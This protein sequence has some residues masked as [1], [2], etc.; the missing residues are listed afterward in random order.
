MKAAGLSWT[1]SRIDNYA[2]ALTDGTVTIKSLTQVATAEAQ[3]R[4]RN[5]EQVAVVGRTLGLPREFID[6]FIDQFIDSGGDTQ[7]AIS[8][9]RDSP[10]YETYFP[11]N[12]REDG[13]V[14][15]NEQQY[16]QVTESYAA[17]LEDY[18]INPDLYESK[19]GEMV[20]GDV[21]P[22]EFFGRVDAINS[23]ILQAPPEVREAFAAEFGVAE[24]ASPAAILGVA[25]APDIGAAVRERRI[26]IAQVTGQAQR[27]GFRRSRERVQEL[28]DL[29]MTGQQAGQFYSGAAA[30]VRRL[31]AGS[32]MTGQDFGI[33]TV[34]D[35]ATGNVNALSTLTRLDAQERSR[36]STAGQV[37]S[38]RTGALTG[39]NRR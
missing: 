28:L 33:N 39:L 38:D 34:E 14:R 15:Y 11:G 31:S 8:S 12:K 37:Q 20:K 6:T 25:L 9:V 18:G 2:E 24:A 35:A 29:G 17:T 5:R 23:R 22:D 19:F 16:R 26:N 32:A 4:A 13:S 1:Q 30:N 27:F 21:S 7:V 3:G 10:A 36:F